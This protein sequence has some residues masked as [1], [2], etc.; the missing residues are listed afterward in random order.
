VISC[1]GERYVLIGSR[2]DTG[3]R[4]WG[5]DIY[6]VPKILPETRMVLRQS[7]KAWLSVRPGILEEYRQ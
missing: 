6:S 3:G 4:E 7:C 1:K 2:L 5:L